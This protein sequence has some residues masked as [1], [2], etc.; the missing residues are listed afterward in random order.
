MKLDVCARTLA[1][2][3]YMYAMEITHCI[4]GKTKEQTYYIKNYYNIIYHENGLD[5]FRITFFEKVYQTVIC[6]CG[7]MRVREHCN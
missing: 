5:K 2:A 4:G 6:L 7:V 3:I 1:E